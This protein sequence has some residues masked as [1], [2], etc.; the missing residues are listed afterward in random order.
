MADDCLIFVHIPKAAGRTLNSVLRRQYRH[1]E[2]IEFNTLDKGLNGFMKI[3]LEERARARL[4]RGHVHYGIH[5][6]LSRHARYITILRDPVDRVLSLYGY[7]LRQPKHPLHA[8]L[9]ASGAGLEEFVRSGIDGT[10]VENGQTRQ[11]AG[12][13]DR[14]PTN[15]DLQAALSNLRSF[16]VVGLTEQFDESL[17]LMKRLFGWRT[18]YY[19]SQNVGTGTSPGSRPISNE[20]LDLIRERNELDLELHAEAKRMFANLV[21]RQDDS[22]GR[23]VA[24]FKKMN[25]FSEVIGSRVNPVWNRVKYSTP[26]DRLRRI[27]R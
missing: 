4:V 10:Q 11:I 22:F 6:W 3:P 16:V 21:G 19:V 7:I 18:P 26:V 17:I 12:I 14:D 9:T 23:E 13:E 2:T 24:R 15:D 27:A 5:H 8:Q 25:R 1:S 20:A